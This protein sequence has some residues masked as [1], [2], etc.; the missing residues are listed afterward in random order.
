MS[1]TLQYGLMLFAAAH[2]L[3]GKKSGRDREPAPSRPGGP[4]MQRPWVPQND[5]QQ[6]VAG[7]VGIGTDVIDA[8][9]NIYESIFKPKPQVATAQPAIEKPSTGFW[10]W[11]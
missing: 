5:S 1:K 6:E 3:S 10:S 9:L 7:W 11:W 8:G 2:F 4:F